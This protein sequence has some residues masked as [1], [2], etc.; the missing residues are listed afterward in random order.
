MFVKYASAALA[1]LFVTTAIPAESMA[2]HR[3]KHRRATVQFYAGPDVV[4]VPRAMQFM[5]GGYALSRSEFDELYAGDE[6]FDESYY[7][8]TEDLAND[9]AAPA[10]PNPVKPTVKAAAPK[11]VAKPQVKNAVTTASISTPEP[12]PEITAP[13]P[14]AKPLAKTASKPASAK[15][16]SCDKAGQ[17]ISGYGFSDVKPHVCSGAVYEFDATRDG[18]Q[19][20]IKLDPAN[21][22]LAEVRKLQ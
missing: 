19:F 5:F 18:K 14:S 22:E 7:D 4:R 13:A 16:L 9:A 11:P 12:D 17:I 2:D 8:A 10:A 6:D 15:A 3:K 20:A 21:G 1:A